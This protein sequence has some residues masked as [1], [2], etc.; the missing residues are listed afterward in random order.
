MSEKLGPIAFEEQHDEVF[1]GRDLG[2]QH[3]YSD[4]I[5]AVIDQEIHAIITLGND[6]AT[7][8]LKE[9]IDQLHKVAHELLEVETMKSE[10][11]LALVD[12]KPIV[13]HAYYQMGLS[14]SEEES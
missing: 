12:D 1:L 6:K 9:H 7:A 4:E 14:D 8:V 3:H 5:A 2:R 10:A 13:K 11:F